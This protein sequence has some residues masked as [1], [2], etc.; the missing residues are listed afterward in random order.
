MGIRNFQFFR[1]VLVAGLLAAAS[2]LAATV[3]PFDHFGGISLA[4]LAGML[5]KAFFWKPDSNSA[6]LAFAAKTLLRIGIVLL[7][8]RLNFAEAPPDGWRNLV[9]AVFRRP[10]LLSALEITAARSG[11]AAA[12]PG[13]IEPLVSCLSVANLVGKGFF[14][15]F[16]IQKG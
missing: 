7:G 13:S 8:F 1:D 16:G 4:L 10:H 9:V 15:G 14:S 2:G 3:S 11:S 6:G 12:G 5:T